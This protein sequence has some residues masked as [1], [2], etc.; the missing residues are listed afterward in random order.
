[1]KA[2]VEV[3]HHPLDPDAI[4][5]TYT[6]PHSET[7]FAEHPPDKTKSFFGKSGKTRLNDR[8]C[9]VRKDGS[10]TERNVA[11]MELL[12]AIGLLVNP[13]GRLVMSR[14][15][16][17]LIDCVNGR[18]GHRRIRGIPMT[19]ILCSRD[20]FGTG[21]RLTIRLMAAA[22]VVRAA[23][24]VSVTIRFFVRAAGRLA[25]RALITIADAEMLQHARDTECRHAPK[26]PSRKNDGKVT[27][28][29]FR[30]IGDSQTPI[31]RISATYS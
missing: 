19:R 24:I 3:R 20:N 11:L 31:N 2:P 6:L 27:L 28:H 7:G 25:F 15:D 8:T 18:N 1:M 26:S 23:R 5:T 14:R 10:D 9:R 16:R 22:H 4:K 17:L 21:I 12:T 13:W 29:S 30:T